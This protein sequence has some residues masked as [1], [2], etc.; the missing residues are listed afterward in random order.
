MAWQFTGI[1][2]TPKTWRDIEVTWVEYVDALCCRFGGKKN[3]LEELTGYKC[4]NWRLYSL[5][6]VEDD[7]DNS[8]EEEPMETMNVEAL[9][10]HLSL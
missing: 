6:I 5:C 3:P 1:R 4:R 7:G 2:I 10:P 8:E 9:T